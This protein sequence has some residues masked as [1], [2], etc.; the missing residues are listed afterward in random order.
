MRKTSLAK[1]K[2]NF[3]R[4][5]DAVEHRQQRVVI[6][7]HGRPV[8]AV[9]PVEVALAPAPSSVRARPAPAAAARRVKRFVD[10]FSAAEPDVSAVADLR[11]G[12]R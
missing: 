11:A 4:L 5:I 3:S 6:L 7:R 2:A 8:A 12:R 9:V 10:E 1:A